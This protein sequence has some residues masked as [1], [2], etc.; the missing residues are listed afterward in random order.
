MLERA[1]ARVPPEHA[2]TDRATAEHALV[3]Y[4]LDRELLHG[5]YSNPLTDADASRLLSDEL[6]QT[7]REQPHAIDEGPTIDE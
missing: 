5:D 6:R 4:A 7:D 2:P 3:L 1:R